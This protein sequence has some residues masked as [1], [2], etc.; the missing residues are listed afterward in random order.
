[1]THS[2][3]KTDYEALAKR[4]EE[5]LDEEVQRMRDRIT[6]LEGKCEGHMAAQEADKAAES[7]EGTTGQDAVWQEIEDWLTEVIADSFYAHWNAIDGARAIVARIKA[8]D[9]PGLVAPL[10]KRA[11]NCPPVSPLAVAWET[12]RDASYYDMW[13]VRP[14]GCTA[15]GE[16]FHLVNG[17]EAQALCQM[18]SRTT[19]TNMEPKP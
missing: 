4:L 19:L 12:F 10:P 18:L 8:G 13:C 16:G 6:Y 14:V 17:D 7:I 15:F 2:P 11:D 1:M 5:A 3:T 9:F